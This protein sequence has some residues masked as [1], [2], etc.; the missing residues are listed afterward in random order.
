MEETDDVEEYSKI[1]ITCS[2]Y[3]SEP[4]VKL[5][6]DLKQENV[7]TFTLK[8]TEAARDRNELKMSDVL[9]NPMRMYF[10]LIIIY[11]FNGHKSLGLC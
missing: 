6:C 1:R 7:N 11:Q 5:L 3:S 9:Q 2:A 10:V 8:I 4:E